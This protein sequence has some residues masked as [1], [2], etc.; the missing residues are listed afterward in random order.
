MTEREAAGC[1]IA[2]RGT[3]IHSESPFGALEWL[4]LSTQLA[5]LVDA[6]NR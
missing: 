6:Y 3:A 1:M 2:P 5:G 4:Q